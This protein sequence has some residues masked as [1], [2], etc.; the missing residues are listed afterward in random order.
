M[1]RALRFLLVAAILGI[2]I[3][4]LWKLGHKAAPA[5]EEASLAGTWSD[6]HFLFDLR[7]DGLYW[8]VAL[9][10]A[11]TVTPTECG[12]WHV[13]AETLQMR[14]TWQAAPSGRARLAEPG[15]PLGRWA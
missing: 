12:R 1:A 10:T 6:E 3:G 11:G 7:P 2:S 13:S 4:V 15:F 9:D 14:A 8:A 5:R